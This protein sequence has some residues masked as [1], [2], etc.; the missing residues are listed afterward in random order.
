MIIF[1][2]ISTLVI[3]SLHKWVMR[4]VDSYDKYGVNHTTQE[5]REFEKSHSILG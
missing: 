4:S 2:L 5:W 3:F 1:F